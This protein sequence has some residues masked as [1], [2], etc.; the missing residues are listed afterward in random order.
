MEAHYTGTQ[1][2]VTD[3]G[4]EQRDGNYFIRAED[5]AQGM[6]KGGWI[7]HMSQKDWVDIEDFKR[8]Y[9]TALRSIT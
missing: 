5:L 2:I 8:A 1:W 9:A 4:V 7:G 6:G 3:D